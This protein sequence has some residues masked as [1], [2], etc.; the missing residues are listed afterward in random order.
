M[1]IVNFMPA[2]KQAPVSLRLLQEHLDEAVQKSAGQDLKLMVPEGSELVEK[3]GEVAA[4]MDGKL[5]FLYTNNSA[6][7]VALRGFHLVPTGPAGTGKTPLVS[8]EDWLLGDDDSKYVWFD[9]A[10]TP[11]KVL[12]KTTGRALLEA[13]GQ[14][15]EDL[16]ALY[17]GFPQS[18]FVTPDQLDEELTVDTDYARVYT[19]KNCM[20][21]ALHEIAEQFH[22]EACG[23][24][25]F[26][27][28][29]GHQI[30]RIMADVVNKKG[31]SGDMA[32]LKDL[33]PVMKD[34]TL[35]SVDSTL[36]Q[37]VSQMLNLFGDEIEAHITK[38]QCPAGECKAFLTFHIL[39]S[40]CTGCG[41]CL[42]ACEEGAIMGKD[43]FV[44]VVDQKKCTQ[45]GKCLEV[46]PENAVVMAGVKKPKTPPRPIPVRVKK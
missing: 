44:H 7:E 43:K 27:Y 31:Q 46:C 34:Q 45:C 18:I 24:C 26:G 37:T 15:T 4:P 8:G 14:S 9:G 11:V 33:C 5:G 40:R 12:A 1:T 13:C 2:Y 28:E 38:K 3:L 39:V 21:N 20:A 36:A 42:D 10:E 25:V 19:S 17:L 32:L 41:K 29:G 16:K 30:N 6:A 23:H 22:A 35:C